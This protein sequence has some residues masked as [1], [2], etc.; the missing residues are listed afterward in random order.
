MHGKDMPDLPLR[1]FMENEL[2]MMSL[3]HHRRLIRLHDAFDTHNTFTLVTDLAGGGELLDTL[4]SRPFYTEWD[5][6]HYIRQLLEGLE[7]MHSLNVAHLGLTVGDLLIS[8]PGGDDLKICDFGLARRISSAGLQPLLYGMPE[9]VAPEVMRGEGVSLSADMWSVGIITYLLLSGHSLFRGENDRETLTKIKEGKWYFDEDLFNNYSA[10]ARDFITKLLAYVPGARLNVEQALDHPWFNIL[11]RTPYDPYRMSSDALKNYYNLYKDWYSNA[12]C[13]NWYRRRPLEGAFTHPSKMV[14]PPYE[15]YTPAPTPEREPY[16]ARNWEEEIHTGG[17]DLNYEIGLVKSESHYQNG[18]DTYLLQ[19]R[20]TDFPVR[21]REYLK[22]AA[23]RGPG[24]SRIVSDQSHLDWRAPVIRERRRFTDVMDEEIDDERKERINK[25]GS[26]DVYSLRRLRHELG[27]RLDGHAEAEA[28]MQTKHEEHDGQLPFFREKPQTVPIVANEV[29]EIACLAVGDPKPLVQWYKCDMVVQETVRIS[30]K[31]DGEGRSIL[32][33]GPA[34]NMDIGI[35]KVVARNK[36]GQT[37]ARFR[38]VLAGVP[39]SPDSPDVADVS[40]DEVFLRWKQPKDDGNTAVICYSLQYKEVDG[41]QWLDVAKN[42]DHEFFVVKN[43]QQMSRYYFRLAAKNRVGWSDYGIP[44]KVKTKPA[45]V[46]KVQI[47]R[48]MAHLQSITESGA[49]VNEME[50]APK[51]DYTIENRPL[52][53]IPEHDVSDKYHFI[54]EISRGRFSVVVKGVEK[55]NDHIVTGKLLELS[56][57][58]EVAVNREF[59]A[60]RR[61]R[62]ERIAQLLE[63]YRAPGAEVAVLIL[64]KLQGADV[65]TYFS[66]RHEYNEQMI[67]NVVSQ[68]LDGLQYLHWRGLCHLDLQPDNIVMASVRSLQVKLVDLGSAQ[69]VSKLGTIV[70]RVGHIEYSSPEMLNDEPVYPQ[71]DIWSLGVVTYILLSGVSPFRG[72][73]NEETRQNI[74]FVRYRFEHLFKELSQEATRFLMLVFKRTPSKRPTI[75]ES[76]EHRW[77]L[78]TEFM[79]KKRE[80]ASFLGIRLKDFCD[81]YHTM[82]A[83][84]AINADS[85]VGSMSSGDSGRRLT[86]SRSDSITEELS[87]AFQNGAVV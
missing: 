32:R 30:F 78:P 59:E 70:D 84:Q 23:N 75:E 2:E 73:N 41:D 63:A 11:G 5:V 64:E 6:A 16:K 68:V 9:F 19:L 82:R 26:G 13:R 74:L 4:T 80:R 1:K 22:V 47:T 25:Y 67:C 58:R 61:L 29:V 24:Y 28:I 38:V 86:L 76:H 17:T 71:S 39:S 44:I 48:A 40:D 60:L 62:H 81:E 72:E 46:P 15:R 45:G 54:S 53:W 18:P 77:L 49:E 43:L 52:N 51:L 21:L 65:L 79:I 83:R 55:S 42:I 35:Y 56:S 57:A 31:E 20:D 7:H 36:G 10:E 34:H 33:L 12:S 50:A 8:H 87:N 69:T 27:T 14:Y 37:V 66:S 85:L 3:L